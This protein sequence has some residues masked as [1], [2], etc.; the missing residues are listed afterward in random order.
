MG[1]TKLKA[2]HFLSITKLSPAE[3]RA[4]IS[5]A[6]ELKSAGR[7]SLLKGRTLAILFEKPSL[8]TRVSFEMA[9]R[10]LGGDAVYLSPAEVGLGTRESIPDVARVLSRYVDAI[11]LRTF[12]QK[13]LEVLAE[14]SSIPVINALSDSEHPCQALADLLTIREK[15]G[16]LEGVKV[17]FIGD[18]NNVANSLGLACAMTGASFNIASPAGHEINKTVLKRIR[19]LAAAS[20]ATVAWGINPEEAVRNADVVYT[21]T[22]TSMG[23]EAEMEKRRKDFAGFQVNEKLLSHAAHDVIVMHCLPAHRGEEVDENILDGPK[24]VVFD[25]AENRLHAQKAIL[26]SMI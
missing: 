25:Q 7:S 12:A 16:R 2:K 11:A 20:G 24:S 1:K 22:W 23:Q 13:N 9:M 18:G 5:Y 4:L 17:A 14:Y 26:A 15:K 21:D 10:Q 6:I 19:T 3:I 8:R